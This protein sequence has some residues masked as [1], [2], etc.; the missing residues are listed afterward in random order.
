MDCNSVCGDGIET[1]VEDC[2]DGNNDGSPPQNF[3]GCSS[4]CEFENGWNRDV[5][6]WQPEC[7]DSYVTGGE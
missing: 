7:G 4:T 6:P 2:D 1:V 5:E 3:D